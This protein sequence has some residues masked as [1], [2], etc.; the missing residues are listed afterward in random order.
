MK[1]A[2]FLIALTSIVSTHLI[3]QENERKLLPSEAIA[4]MYFR[5]DMN[6][7]ASRDV[8]TKPIQPRVITEGLSG[9]EWF[10][11]GETYFWNLMP[12]EA[13]EAFSKIMDQNTNASRAAWQRM[14]IVNVNGFQKFEETEKMIEDY[15]KKF[16][17]IP[18]DISGAYFGISSLAYFYSQQE[19]HEKVVQLIMDEIDYL[20]FSGPY[21]GFI[22]P[23]HYMKS[24]EALGKKKEA[25]QMLK[26]AVKGLSATLSKR[27]ENTPE[28]DIKYAKHS[29]PVHNMLTVMTEKIGYSQMNEN[30]EKLI[31]RIENAIA[32]NSK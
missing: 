1:K 21:S 25:I 26:D 11:L 22:G 6:P 28:K 12:N 4:L 14:M 20:D 2:I 15:R 18:E 23:S 13:K 8:N 10:F 31:E 5:V 9:D 27:K 32:E 3:A 16:K 30:F 17:P 7:E 19:K 29:G 24:F